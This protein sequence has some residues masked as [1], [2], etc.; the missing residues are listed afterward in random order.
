MIT[1]NELLLCRDGLHDTTHTILTT[2]IVTN[3]QRPFVDIDYITWTRKAP[4]G[5]RIKRFN[6]EDLDYPGSYSQWSIPSIPDRYPDGVHRMEKY[7]TSASLEFQGTDVF[8][9]GGFGPEHGQYKVALDSRPEEIM[10]GSAMNA[11]LPSLL[12]GRS[13]LEYGSHKLVVTNVEEG[14]ILDIYRAEVITFESDDLKPGAIAGIV[15]GIVVGLAFV[16]IFIWFF[17]V[18]RRRGKRRFSTDLFGGPDVSQATAMRTYSAGHDPVIIELFTG[19]PNRTSG[20]EVTSSYD[21]GRGR[22]GKTGT[23]GVYV[24]RTHEAESSTAVS[25]IGTHVERDAGALPPGYNDIDPS[26]VADAPYRN[27]M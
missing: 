11:H 4:S 5:A 9:Y 22:V 12:Y 13:Y 24:S 10:N 6:H 18:K 25:D 16:S 23:P 27:A 21:T 14:K 3:N 7:G 8:L 26:R 17:F 20:S 15:V 1:N 19:G 2:S